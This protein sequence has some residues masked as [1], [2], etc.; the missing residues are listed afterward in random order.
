MAKNKMADGIEFV[1]SAAGVSV[2]SGGSARRPA[3]RPKKILLYQ[4]GDQPEDAHVVP[5]GA[6]HA[7]G[8][9]G[10]ALAIDG[11]DLSPRQRHFQ[12]AYQ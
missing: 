10:R 11:F 12:V 3:V 2:S 6:Q 4:S 9:G 7:P 1:T 5:Y 8:A